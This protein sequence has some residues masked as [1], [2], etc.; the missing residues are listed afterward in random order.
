[1]NFDDREA[2]SAIIERQF[3]S[4]NWSPTTPANWNAFV[5]DF[6]PGASLYPAARPANPQKSEDFVERMKGLATSKLRAFKEAALG[7]R[8]MIRK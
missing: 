3:G 8:R 1:M 6:V 4:L 2:I 7:P 5:G